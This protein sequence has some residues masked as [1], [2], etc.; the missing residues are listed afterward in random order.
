MLGRGGTIQSAQPASNGK[1]DYASL[2]RYCVVERMKLFH[3]SD[4]PG[5]HVF[6]PRR[7]TAAPGLGAVV[8]A[9]DDAHLP[10]YLLP[11]DCPRVILTATARSSPD[12]RQRF[13]V[14]KNRGWSWSRA[15]GFNILKPRGSSATTFHR[16]PFASTMSS[17]VGA[18]RAG[19]A[20]RSR[21][22]PRHSW[23]PGGTRR[24]ASRRQQSM[25][26]TPSGRTIDVGVF[27]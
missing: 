26:A 11:R 5:V 3:I 13:G 27:R 7:A 8:W 9:V 6:M 4:E 10:N 21:C 19:N 12:D 25:V 20:P 14:R 16:S 22:R 18:T 1:L 23:F 17:R 24:G 15:P 2:R